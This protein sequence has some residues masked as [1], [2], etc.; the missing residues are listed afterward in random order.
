M[1]LPA[2]GDMLMLVVIGLVILAI[3]LIVLAVIAKCK[4]RKPLQI[5]Y[6]DI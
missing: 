5:D 1:K 6:P 3:S 4:Q 2:T